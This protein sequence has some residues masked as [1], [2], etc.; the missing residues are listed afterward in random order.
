MDELEHNMFSREAAVYL[1]QGE[2]DI[3]VWHQSGR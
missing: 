2:P 3:I 1:K